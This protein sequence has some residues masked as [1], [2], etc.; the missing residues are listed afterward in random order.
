MSLK[1]KN[2]YCTYNIGL[3]TESDALSDISFEALRGEILSIVGRT[4][5]GKSTLAQHLNALLLPQ[6]GEVWVDDLKVTPDKK[7][8][9]EFRLDDISALNVGD[10]IKADVFEAGE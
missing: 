10:I 1:V 6:R 7:T 8:L 3:P 2:L 4:G 9:R 5:S